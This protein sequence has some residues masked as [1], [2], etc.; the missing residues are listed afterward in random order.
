MTGQLSGGQRTAVREAV[1]AGEPL[2]PRLAR[3]GQEEAAMGYL[4]FLDR[5]NDGSMLDDGANMAAGVG[6]AGLAA[7]GAITAGA[8]AATATVGGGIM[9]LA[10]MAETFT[11]GVATPLAAPA[12]ILGACLVGGGA[13]AGVL[14]GAEIGAGGVLAAASGT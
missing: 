8:G 12:A 3:L 13:L 11:G 7:L 2:R 5:D 1:A 14:G 10:G 4:D 9:G 6:G